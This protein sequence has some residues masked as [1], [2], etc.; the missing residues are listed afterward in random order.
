MPSASVFIHKIITRKC[1]LH[2]NDKLSWFS[3]AHHFSTESKVILNLTIPKH[4]TQGYKD[5][6]KYA[7]SN[8]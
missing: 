1:P 2:L 6:F 4:G 8:I 5:S 3:D 7:A